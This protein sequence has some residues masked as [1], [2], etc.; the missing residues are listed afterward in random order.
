MGVHIRDFQV[1]PAVSPKCRQP[2]WETREVG[3]PGRHRPS[4]QL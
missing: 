4:P 1:L 2:T 3:S